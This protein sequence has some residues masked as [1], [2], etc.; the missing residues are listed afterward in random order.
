MPNSIK[1]P[2]LRASFVQ[3]VLDGALVFLTFRCIQG[4]FG[5][6]WEGHYVMAT[7]TVTAL[8]LVF[9]EL[10]SL[11]RSWRTSSLSAEVR[12]M[13]STWLSVVF[14]LLVLI[15]ASRTS[16]FFSRTVV[17]SW[18]LTV[19]MVLALSRVAVRSALRGIRDGGANIRTV[20]IVGNN[21][22][23]H[24]LVLHLERKSWAGLVVKGLFSDYRKGQTKVTIGTSTYNLGSIDEL[25]DKVRGGEIDS[26]YIALHLKYESRI[27]ELVNELSDTTA[28]V[29][30]MPDLF[31][32]E[33]MHAR[34]IDFSGLPLVSIYETP[35]DGLD[36]WIKRLEDVVLAGAILALISPAMMLIAAAVK[37]TSPGPIIF[38]QRRY[39]LNGSVV[40]VWKFRSMTVCDDGDVVL[41]ATK[42]DSRVTPLGGF[43]RRTSLDELPQFINVLQGRMSVVGPRPHAVS[44]NEEYRKIIKGYMLRHKVKPGITGWAQINGW[45]GET[46]TLEKMQKRV[47]FDLAYIQNWSVWFDL[48][49]VFLTVFRGFIGKNVY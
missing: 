5:V 8:F 32:S 33:L 2:N 43:L 25:L 42:N 38:K 6:P 1:L 48:K 24:R 11:Y 13:F 49:I 39:G 3:R 35:F 10:N 9:A 40:E 20:A 4:Y 26:V 31:V 15:F 44:H 14:T 22:A 36:G 34:L 47:E 23:A 7:V 45:R 30:I 18:W 46:D 21:E 19:P 17:I 37:A 12:E 27:A 41:Q 28:S 29:F 16:D